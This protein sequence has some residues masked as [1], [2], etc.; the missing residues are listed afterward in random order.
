VTRTV[1]VTAPP[2]LGGGVDETF[3]GRVVSASAA[4]GGYYV[5]FDPAWWL[6]GV[7]ASVAL[8][9][10]QHRTCATPACKEIPVP[11]DY[12][13]LDE[14]RQTLTFFLPRTAHGTVLSRPL[15]FP[16][17]RIT[18]D[19]LVRLLREGPR[20]NLFEPLESGLWLRT[21]GG[22]VESFAQQYRP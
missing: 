1:T 11:D 13:V 10:A 18:A 19:R 17:A 2:Q 7:S 4:P 20:A 8:A 22:T 16:G 5:R 6:S 3:Y 12:Y 15:R 14:G 9:H 21:R